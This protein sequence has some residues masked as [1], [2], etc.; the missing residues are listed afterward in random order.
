[1]VMSGDI[2]TSFKTHYKDSYKGWLIDYSSSKL[3]KHEPK[4]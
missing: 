2:F 3:S 4:D 1:M